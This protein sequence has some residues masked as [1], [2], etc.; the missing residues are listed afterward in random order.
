MYIPHANSHGRQPRNEPLSYFRID[1]V[2]K[3]ARRVN[4]QYEGTTP[5]GQPYLGFM[6]RPLPTLPRDIT[7]RI[8]GYTN[9]D[10]ERVSGV[11]EEDLWKLNR[12]HGS[13]A[14]LV[15][16][17]AMRDEVRRLR[18]ILN[19]PY[20]EQHLDMWGQQIRRARRKLNNLDSTLEHIIAVATASLYPRG[21]FKTFRT[22]LNVEKASAKQRLY[23][24]YNEVGWLA[25]TI[26]PQEPLLRGP[27]L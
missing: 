8:T 12:K 13:T 1:D 17:R 3:R 11:T 22:N 7:R 15:P 4:I 16:I 24:L 9:N 25:S 27:G 19:R 2:N 21:A 6:S 20:P 10:N 23:H 5:E 18:N 26:A 14:F